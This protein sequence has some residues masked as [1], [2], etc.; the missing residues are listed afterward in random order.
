MKDIR[1]KRQ[2]IGHMI[3]VWDMQCRTPSIRSELD[4]LLDKIVGKTNM[5]IDQE[6]DACYVGQYIGI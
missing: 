4:I 6:S 1:Q 3:C 2:N 5:L